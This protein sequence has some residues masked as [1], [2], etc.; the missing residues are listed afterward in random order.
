MK[1]DGLLVSSGGCRSTCVT[2]APG[3]ERSMRYRQERVLMEK[4]NN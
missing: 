1:I 4:E 3:I 2:G